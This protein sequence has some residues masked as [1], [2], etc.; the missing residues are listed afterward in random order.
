MTQEYKPK[1]RRAG[2]SPAASMST[3]V[4]NLVHFV[5]ATANRQPL[6]CRA[7]RE[8]L[9]S[10]IGGILNHKRAKLL[11]AGGVEDHVHVLASL[12]A[13]LSLADAASAMK[14]NSSRWI[15]E[16]APQAKGFEWQTGY[17]AFSV[18][19][20]AR[21]K[22]TAYINNQEEHHKR[23]QFTEEFKRLLETHGIPFEERYLWV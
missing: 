18:S 4:S 15:H 11:A 13:T 9:H 5:W 22:V 8:R 7:W 16:N 17:G 20:S 1:A 14:S 23:W 12:P 10:Y 21:D 6:I 19:E 2:T 3:Y